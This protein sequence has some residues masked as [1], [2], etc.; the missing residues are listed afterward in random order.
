MRAP[1]RRRPHP[2]S[3]CAEAHT[4]RPAPARS[5]IATALELIRRVV[6]ARF[7]G[8]NCPLTGLYPETVGNGGWGGC[9]AS[10][11]GC[12]D[13]FYGA[14]APGAPRSAPL[15]RISCVAAHALVPLLPCTQS[16]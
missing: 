1:P 12:S 8:A 11:G 13:S 10:M 9:V 7:N 2:H 15:A 5:Y 14:S 3:F 6:P 4:R 16:T